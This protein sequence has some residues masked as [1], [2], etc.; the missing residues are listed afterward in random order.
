MET[1]YPQDKLAENDE[2]GRRTSSFMLV[3]V[4]PSASSTHHRISLISTT[5]SV[6]T[7]ILLLLRAETPRLQISLKSPSTK[8]WQDLSSSDLSPDWNTCIEPTIYLLTQTKEETDVCGDICFQFLQV[9]FV[10]SGNP[11]SSPHFSLGFLQQ[12]QA[13]RWQ[14]HVGQQIVLQGTPLLVLFVRELVEERLEKRGLVIV[15]REQGPI[16]WAC[17]AVAPQSCVNKEPRHFN[18]AQSHR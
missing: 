15:V 10:Q 14:E 4:D 7:F 2:V 9:Y 8:D 13:V 1:G 11:T 16:V 5:T 18:L 17:S 6:C 12:L 3:F